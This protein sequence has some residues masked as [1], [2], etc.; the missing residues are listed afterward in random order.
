MALKNLLTKLSPSESS[1]A[2]NYELRKYGERFAVETNFTGSSGDTKGPFP[3]LAKYI[4]FFGKPE[5]EGDIALTAPIVKKKPTKIA[6]TAP[7][8]VTCRDNSKI[9]MFIMPQQYKSLDSIPKPTNP[10]VRIRAIPAATGAVY[11]YSGSSDDQHAKELAL[12]LGAQLRDDGVVITDEF[13]EQNF[14]Y[15]GYNPPFTLPM[16]RRNE[17]WIELSSEQVQHLVSKSQT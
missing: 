3:R 4:G 12:K 13:I 1:N 2:V 15:W 17:V 14:E 5:N 9:M 16:Y 6:M 8:A 7:V 11:R 10:D